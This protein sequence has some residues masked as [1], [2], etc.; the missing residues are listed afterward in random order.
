MLHA[1]EH[2]SFPLGP[3]DTPKE[4]LARFNKDPYSYLEALENEYGSVFSLQLGSL[5]NES[6]VDV[7]SNGSWVF[8]SRPHQIK[9]MYSADGETVSGALANK[10]F[11][12]TNEESVAYIEGEA[13]R[14]RR[15]Q[16]HPSFSGI[17]DYVSIIENV[18]RRCM[19]N[20]PRQEP[21][22]LFPEL[23]KLTAEIIVEVVCGNLDKSDRA[24]LCAMMPKTESAHCTRDELREADRIIRAYIQDRISGYLERSDAHGQDDVFTTLLKL[25]A[26][27]D[28]SL[29]SE[30]V[31]DEV[32]SLLYTGFS[33]TANTLA[34]AFV[35][36][37]SHPEVYQKLVKELDE[38]FPREHL[39]GESLRGL[40]YL[41]A[42]IKETLR[43]HP[44]TPL[45]GVR[46]VKKPLRIDEYLIPKGTILVH[47]AYLLQRSANVYE[48][49]EKFLPERFLNKAVD[50]Y[51]WGAFGGGSRTCIGRSFSREEMKLVLAIVLSTLRIELT[52][53]IPGAKQQGFFMAPED[54]APC[55]IG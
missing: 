30:V 18:T 35:C 48:D 28:E 14:Y 44:V 15:S 49:P 8:L 4:Q 34:W 41:D 12:G 16:L 10:V 7:E 33:T 40:S 9:I 51:V 24:Q 25:G 37:L 27:G 31:R 6:N 21:F 17:R 46:M 42:A 3:M 11:F 52:G 23:Q 29:S 50:P 19:A 13:H 55:V 26:K 54:G 38:K 53:G 2:E 47:C 36:I 45:N 43:L 39:R 22:K 20:W 1:K 32:F 5:G